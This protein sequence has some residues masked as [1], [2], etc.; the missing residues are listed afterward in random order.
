MDVETDAL[1]QYTIRQNFSD[2]TTLTIA[3][4]LNTIIDC[5]MILVLEL[6]RVKEFDTPKALLMN[7]KSEFFSMV[8]ETGPKN[9]AYLKSI[10]IDGS[11]ADT[12]EIELLAE[13]GKQ[14]LLQDSP[15]SRFQLKGDLMQAVEKAAWTLKAGWENRNS[16][17]W[18]D[19]LN[20]YGVSQREWIEYMFELL[21]MARMSA[22]S[23]L[24]EDHMDLARTGF[25]LKDLAAG[26][27]LPAIDAHLPSK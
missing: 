19:E 12:K 25:E 15:S 24:S 7:E 6:G 13:A 3:H 16:P 8:E 27:A 22:E 26:A 5:D 17:E 9:A 4:R 18:L 2:R 10:A 21:Q 20:R 1:I 23:A 11:V 14:K